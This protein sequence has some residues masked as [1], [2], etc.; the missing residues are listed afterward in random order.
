MNITM[1]EMGNR[2][3]RSNAE[4]LRDLSLMI[5]ERASCH[6]DGQ[7][8]ILAG[9]KFEFGRPPREWCWRTKL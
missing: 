8:L 9:T 2:I 5:Y 1:E 4:L 6:V 7:D 3:G